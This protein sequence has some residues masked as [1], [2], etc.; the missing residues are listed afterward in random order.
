MKI[1]DRISATSR[2]SASIAIAYAIKQGAHRIEF[3]TEYL[4]ELWR[5]CE[6]DGFDFAILA[7]QAD[8]ECDSYRSQHFDEKGN[9]VG[10]GKTDSQDLSLTYASGVD[11]AR[12]HLMHIWVYVRG[13]TVP[14]AIRHWIE[15]DP[16]YKA[17]LDANWGGKVMTLADFNHT[18][19]WASAA[20]TPDGYGNRIVTR[21]NRI[22]PGL[23]QTPGPEPEPDPDTPTTFAGWL[24]LLFGK[25]RWSITQDWAARGGPDL[26][27]Y[28]KGH[29]LDGSQHTGVDVGMAYGTMMRAPARG[30]I[31]CA[32]TGVG[33]GANGNGCSAYRD[34]GDG[35]EGSGTKGVGRIE[36]YYPAMNASL[37]YGHSRTCTKRP[38][39]TV[40]RGD[41]IGTSGGMFGPHIHLEAIQWGTSQGWTL[42]DPRA[43]FMELGSSP[44][45]PPEEP[46]PMTLT[47]RQMLVTSGPN[48]PG[49][50]LNDD[51]LYITVHETDNSGTGAN[52]V[53]HANYV[54]NG[55]GASQ[56]SFHNSVDSREFVQIMP[57]N[58]VGYHA[59]DGCNDR[60]TDFGCFQSIAIETCVN[61]DGDYDQTIRNLIAGIVAIIKGDSRLDFAGRS[62]RFSPDRIRQHNDW[63][64]KYCPR[65]IRDRGL[66]PFILQEVR[67]GV[68]ATTPTPTTP[69][70]SEYAPPI[71]IPYL[72]T[73][74]GGDPNTLAAIVTDEGTDYIYVN[75]GVR[76]IRDTPR[77][78]RANP[79]AARVGKHIRKGQE[80]TVAW[81]LT[82]NDGRQYYLT[83]AWTRVLVRDTERIQD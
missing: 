47:I 23:E 49:T 64:G 38:G 63:S 39:D 34:W 16:R 15:L 61:A 25:G 48:I 35:G 67:K 11:M 10:L 70:P 65:K 7:A 27:E 56:V 81:M 17:V 66:W 80:F 36:I 58:L 29:G 75:D 18:G 28:G 73:M 69:P 21:G 1:T 68:T 42:R 8:N 45:P 72:E 2:G 6:L 19:Y 3:V 78:Q 4:H 52:A 33:Q 77:L 71:P 26:Y 44:A 46:E 43:F 55:G 74:A 82:A 76:A 60:A 22:F 24:D 31:V 51:D 62:G 53:M 54:R 12:A 13:D 5:I 37:I 57:F 40:E 83:P 50:V 79:G 41:I 30:V 32:G 59:G 20:S 14:L 9:T